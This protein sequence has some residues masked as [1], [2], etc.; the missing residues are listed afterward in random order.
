MFQ[1]AASISPFV[2]YPTHI[3]CHCICSHIFPPQQKKQEI[4]PGGEILA[5]SSLL[6]PP[7]FAPKTPEI[8]SSKV[9]QPTNG[10]PQ[11]R[12]C[13]P[14]E[15]LLPRDLAPRKGMDTKNANSIQFSFGP[16][17]TKLRDACLYEHP[18]CVPHR[19]NSDSD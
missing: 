12:V 16:L 5:F 10:E 4:R 11:G 6:I 13:F 9:P 1:L 7:T 18:L 2:N 17:L 19:S 8:S 3:S 14:C 15:S